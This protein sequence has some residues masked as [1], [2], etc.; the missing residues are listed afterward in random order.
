[1]V[2]AVRSPSFNQADRAYLTKRG[3]N[4]PCKCGSGKKSEKCCGSKL[5]TDIIACERCRRLRKYCAKVAKE[6]RNLC[7]RN[8]LGKACSEF[9]IEKAKVLIVGLA[10]AA[11]GANRTGR[12]FTGDNSG[13]WLYRA[14]DK[15]NYPVMI[16]NVAHC[17]PPENKLTPKE[18]DNCS[19]YC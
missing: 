7:P 19:E 14:L 3:R 18:L 10:P 2:Q 1:M 13:V 15:V 8:L 6:K 4:D 12:M 17:A 5:N 16:T 9:R 11:H